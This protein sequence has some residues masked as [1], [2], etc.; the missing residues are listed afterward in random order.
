VGFAKCFM[1]LFILMS[2]MCLHY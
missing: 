1:K 2:A